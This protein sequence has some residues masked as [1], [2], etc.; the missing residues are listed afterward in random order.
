MSQAEIT[1][2]AQTATAAQIKA[3]LLDVHTALPGIIINFDPDTR[4]ATV[5]PAI[6]R[7]FI[8]R[9][10][11]P[12]PTNLPPLVDVLVNF[13]GGGDYELTFPVRNG[14]HCLL[15]FSERCIDSWFVTGQPAPPDDYRQHDLSDAFAFV[16][17]APLG[18]KE[19]V[20]MGGTE[21]KGV[22][23]SIRMSDTQIEQRLGSDYLRLSAGKLETNCVIHAPNVITPIV[24]VNTH[25]H[26]AKPPTVLGEVSGM[27]VPSGGGA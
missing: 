26:P 18:S 13:S 1:A 16:G 17:F 20:W 24:N 10:G 23:S 15:C 9:N 7:V 5:Q 21:I 4:T 8:D 11:Q 2:N 19:P 14:N 27:P 12:I 3:A 22:N 6:Q 25:V